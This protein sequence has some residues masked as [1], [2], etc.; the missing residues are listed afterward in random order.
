[1]DLRADHVSTS[2]IAYRR[3]S[4]VDAFW[5]VSWSSRHKQTNTKGTHVEVLNHYIAILLRRIRG[6]H[7]ERVG[8]DA[9]S[10]LFLRVERHQRPKK[11][12]RN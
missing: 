1:M 3:P 2:T 4:G 11:A 12:P 9:F 6:R 10:D 8:G 5:S 7:V